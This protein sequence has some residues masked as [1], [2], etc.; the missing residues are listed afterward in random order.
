ML[1]VIDD[2]CDKR[3]GVTQAENGLACL[4]FVI[5]VRK[6]IV[7]VLLKLNQLSTFLN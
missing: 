3:Q 5:V 4:L 6:V 7:L 1:L 2:T